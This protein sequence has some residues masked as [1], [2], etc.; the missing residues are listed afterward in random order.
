MRVAEQ[1]AYLGELHG[2]TGADARD[3]ALR[4]LDRFGL[5]NVESALS[6]AGG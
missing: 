2:M 5:A 6:L 4:W 1:L 3:A